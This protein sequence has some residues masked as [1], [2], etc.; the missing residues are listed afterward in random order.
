MRRTF[1]IL[2]VLFV[3]AA[4]VAAQASGDWIKYTSAEGRYSVS[5]PHE[6][7]VSTQDSTAASGEKLVQFR[8]MALDGNGGFLVGYFDYGRG[9]TFSLDEA[10]DGIVANLHA[11]VLGEDQIRLGSSAGKQLKFL[12]KVDAG[13]EVLDRARMYNVRRRI[14]ILQCIF[15]KAED[16]PEV[17]SRCEKFFD[18][19][20]IQTGR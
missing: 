5:L 10:R 2:L 14:Y 6:P 1:A 20:R 11:T 3:S 19:F 17:I 16:G 8:A 15:P 13:E 12:A 4:V 7:K 9:L 18:S